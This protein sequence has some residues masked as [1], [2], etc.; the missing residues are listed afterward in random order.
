MCQGYALLEYEKFEEAKEAVDT[1]NGKEL[2]DK[3][4]SVDFAFRK[5]ALM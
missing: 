3:Q 5:G 2:Y 1:M 4:I